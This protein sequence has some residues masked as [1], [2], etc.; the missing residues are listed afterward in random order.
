MGLLGPLRLLGLL[1]PLRLLGPLGPL[2]VPRYMLS[3]AVLYVVYVVFVLFS[4]SFAQA[5]MPPRKSTYLTPWSER[6]GD[7]VRVALIFIFLALAT[8]RWLRYADFAPRCSVLR[9]ATFA[10]LAGSAQAAVPPYLTPW[11]ER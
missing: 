9:S 3:R 11:P 1:G 8:L 10:S 7:K 4:D 6:S 2:G 5:A